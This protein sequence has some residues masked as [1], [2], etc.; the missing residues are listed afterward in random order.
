MIG[1]AEH[2]LLR[3]RCQCWLKPVGGCHAIDRDTDVKAARPE[4]VRRFRMVHPEPDLLVCHGQHGASGKGS[5]SPSPDMDLHSTP[6]RCVD[7]LL[8]QN[9]PQP[10]RYQHTHFP[11]FQCVR[12]AI[13]P[14]VVDAPLLTGSLTLPPVRL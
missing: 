12:D 2:I 7:L 1:I 4:E 13:R 6:N 9:H 11:G 5:S 14:R 3:L 10:D 8:R